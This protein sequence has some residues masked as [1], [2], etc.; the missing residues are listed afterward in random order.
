MAHCSIRQIARD[1]GRRHRVIQYEINRHHSRDG[2][3]S[4]ILAQEAADRM[5]KKQRN[6]KRKLDTDE[7]LRNHVISELKRGRSP[8]VISGRLRIEPPPDLQGKTIS[9]EAIYDWI[10]T[11]EGRLLDLHRYLHSG[12]PKRRNRHGRK[13]RKTSIHNRISIHERPLCAAERKEVGHWESD[14]VIFSKQRERLSVQYEKKSRYVMIHRLPNGTAEATEEAIR[15]SIDSI[16]LYAWKTLTFDNG[17]EG[18]NH[19]ILR[20]QYGIQT[21][22]CDPFASWQ[23]GGVEHAN[24][25]IR[26]YLPRRTDMSLITQKDIYAIQE[27]INDTPRKILGYKTP[28]EVLAEA[29]G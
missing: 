17:G 15:D 28:K 4:A 1:L 11:G 21:Y 23:K 5:R 24:G 16:P 2:T 14:S 6:R 10:Q 12:R 20:R 25:I 7:A 22:F 26:R 27:K 3:Y 9:H 8:D 29:C 13:M 19:S 18:A